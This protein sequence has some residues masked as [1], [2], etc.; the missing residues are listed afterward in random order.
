MMFCS[1]Y[2]CSAAAASGAVWVTTSGR[3]LVVGACREHPVP[4]PPAHWRVL[5]RTDDPGGAFAR[6]HGRPAPS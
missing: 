6:F 2:G 5:S 1:T 4:E 3:C